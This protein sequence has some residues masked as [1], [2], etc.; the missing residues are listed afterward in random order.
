MGVNWKKQIIIFSGKFA[1]GCPIVWK[2]SHLCWF[3][4]YLVPLDFIAERRGPNVPV[5]RK[6]L[7]KA[8][9]PHVR[10]VDKVDKNT[11][12][13][14]LDRCLEACTAVWID[15]CSVAGSWIY[16]KMPQDELH[17]HLQGLFWPAFDTFI[18]YLLLSFVWISWSSGYITLPRTITITITLIFK[19]YQCPGNAGQKSLWYS[20]PHTYAHNGTIFLFL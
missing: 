11:H 19:M 16:T 17:G 5:L 6:L 10:E 4:I 8:P 20:Q 7:V 13:Y 2:V 3:S 12:L 15:S 1:K 9:M 14:P 18:L